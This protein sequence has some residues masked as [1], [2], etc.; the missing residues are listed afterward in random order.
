MNQITR[1]LKSVLKNFRSL[2]EDLSQKTSGKKIHR[3][4]ILTR[5]LRAAHWLSQKIPLDHSFSKLQKNLRHL[6]HQLGD[7][8]ELDVLVKDGELFKFDATATQVRQQK[9]HKKLQKLLNDKG[10]EKAILKELRRFYDELEKLSSVSKTTL[11]E[12]THQQKHKWP[13]AFPQNKKTLHQTRI[14][15]KKSFYRLE[16]LGKPDPDLKFLQKSLGRAHDLEALSKEFKSTR[17]IES[18]QKRLLT[19]AEKTYRKVIS[20]IAKS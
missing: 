13:Q 15:I 19:K 20:S 11:A 3:L 2:M 12:I 5:R 8:R 10:F 16:I 7:C 1:Q 9:A 4:R 14:K 6:G 18:E 17:Q